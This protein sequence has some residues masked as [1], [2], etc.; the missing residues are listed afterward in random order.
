[1]RKKV[2]NMKLEVTKEA[3]GWFASELDLKSGDYVQFVVKIY[4]GIPTAHEGFYLGLSVGKEGTI[5]IKDEVEG[6]TFYIS[7]EDSWL[8]KHHDLKVIYKNEDVEYLFT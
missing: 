8:L 6:I 5:G 4:G 1:M 3:A 7:E 2:S